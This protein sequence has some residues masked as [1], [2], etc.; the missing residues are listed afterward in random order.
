MKNRMGRILLEQR[1]G[2]GCFMERAG[3]RQITPDE[4]KEMK[5]TIKGF[6]KLD[7]TMTYHHIRE[8]RNGG[9]VTV[10]NGANL[11]AYNHQWLNEQPPEVQEQINRKLQQFKFRIDAAKMQITDTSIDFKKIDISL[12]P[13][14]FQ[15]EIPVYD[16]SI[17]Q[18][19]ER[20]REKFNRARE[21][22]KTKRRLMEEIEDMELGD[23]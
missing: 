14:D 16:N 17:E 22:E 15:I 3:I 11:A 1:Y 10:E 21:K 2:K 8:K 7:R 13:E 4:E 5:R 23:Y 19:K 12:N 18:E 20:K 9:K 6:K